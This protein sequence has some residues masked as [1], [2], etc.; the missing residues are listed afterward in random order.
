MSGKRDGRPEIRGTLKL[1]LP[2]SFGF[3]LVLGFV[4]E[5]GLEVVEPLDF[6]AVVDLEFEDFVTADVDG[7]GGLKALGGIAFVLGVADCLCRSCG[8]SEHV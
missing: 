8:V 3:A 4:V 7:R 6:R 1:L 2:F 5:R